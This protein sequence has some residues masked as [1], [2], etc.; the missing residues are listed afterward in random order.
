MLIDISILT[1]NIL[2]STVYLVIFKRKF[3]PSINLVGINFGALGFFAFYHSLEFNTSTN[4]KI[5]LMRYLPL[6]VT[7]FAL[8]LILAELFHKNNSFS[9]TQTAQN[10]KFEIQ[11]RRNIELLLLRGLNFF[12]IFFSIIHFLRVGIVVFQSNV[13]TER[14]N[15]LGTSG[16]FGIPSRSLLLLLPITTATIVIFREKITKFEVIFCISFFFMT[17]FFM[18]FKGGMYEALL[19]VL[20]AYFAKKDF[21]NRKIFTL[22]TF[23]VSLSA[24]LAVLVGNRYSSLAGNIDFEYFSQRILQ[25]PG[26]DK[27]SALIL[28]LHHPEINAL[29]LDWNYFLNR[30]FYENSPELFPFDKLVSSEI[31]GTARSLN[32][33][34]VSVTVGGDAYLATFLPIPIIFLVYL[35]MGFISE[36]ASISLFNPSSPI[37]VALLFIVIFNIRIF[38]QNGGLVYLLINNFLSVIVVLFLLK[39]LTYLL[40]PTRTI[41]KL[42]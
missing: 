34:L 17:R 18:G 27:V 28:K 10:E 25:A 1:S 40:Y 42:Q 15:S 39:I 23:G 11:A 12:A 2:A 20:A 31:T 21:L 13:E 6:T 4:E 22:A 26:R 36:K 35:F 37:R 33:Y 14:F 29:K 7:F 16:L 30:Y 32:S 41:S 19:V 9:N 38:T 8:G 24:F 5:L 3:I